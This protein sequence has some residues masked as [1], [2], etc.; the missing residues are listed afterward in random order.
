MNDEKIIDVEPVVEETPKPETKPNPVLVGGVFA[1][2]YI[3]DEKQTIHY[4]SITETLDGEKHPW[5]TDF[6]FS[7]LIDPAQVN[8]I[9]ENIQAINKKEITD[10]QKQNEA[11]E[12]LSKYITDIDFG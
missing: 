8:D 11:M 9:I 3:Q 5:T 10:D 12:L 2:V 7:Y 6:M 4:Y 1:Q